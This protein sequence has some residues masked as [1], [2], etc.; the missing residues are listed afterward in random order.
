MYMNM[1]IRG[2]NG[3]GKTSIGQRMVDEHPQHEKI[4]GEFGNHNYSRKA[5][6][7]DFGGAALVGRYKSGVDGI[8]PQ[9][10]IETLIET[11]AP[12][13]H[14]IWENVLISGNF[15]RWFEHAQSLGDTHE[16][17]WLLLDTPADVCIQRI[18]DRRARAIAAGSKHKAHQQKGFREDLVR[19]QH[20][21]S[22]KATAEGGQAGVRA[23]LLDHTKA[24]EQVHDMWVRHGWDCTAGHG[25]LLPDD[26]GPLPLDC[27]RVL[28]EGKKGDYS[29]TAQETAS[30]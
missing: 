27:E 10:Q 8:I 29:Y 1:N 26:P 17:V 23:L 28:V 6:C 20:W 21:R 30:E 15:P 16:P 18:K 11:F 5:I 12:L 19:Y 24:Y 4:K 3:S 25:L 2:T 22:W 7:H 9:T 13:G 14:I